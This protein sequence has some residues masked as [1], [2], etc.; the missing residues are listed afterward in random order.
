MTEGVVAVADPRQ[1][2]DCAIALVC[3]VYTN[4]TGHLDLA[5]QD[6]VIVA[7]LLGAGHAITNNLREVLEALAEL[8]NKAD[9][10]DLI[11]LIN[12]ILNSLPFNY[13]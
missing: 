8:P 12:R 11:D 4:D 9:E 10:D 13:R 3:A 5:R 1:L 6:L 2:P 7:D